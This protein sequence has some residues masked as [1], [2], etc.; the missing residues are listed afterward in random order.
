MSSNNIACSREIIN[1][2][3]MQ[4][5]MNTRHHATKVLK[6][7]QRGNLWKIDQNIRP[8]AVSEDLILDSG[9]SYSDTARGL[10]FY[11]I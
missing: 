6:C 8:R 10:M 1:E 7:H 3:M 9:K 11:L 2:S 5:Y 4:F